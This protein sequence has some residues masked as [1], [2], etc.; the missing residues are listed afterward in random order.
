MIC[1]CQWVALLLAKVA[2]NGWRLG[3]RAGERKSYPSGFLLVARHSSN[4]FGSALAYC[5]GSDGSETFKFPLNF[6]RA[7]TQTDAKPL[8]VRS[9]FYFLYILC[10]FKNA[11]N[12]LLRQVHAGEQNLFDKYLIHYSRHR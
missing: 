12:S 4:K 9:C 7:Y 11:L 6:P 8:V 5:V 2:A 10:L 3:V 1:H